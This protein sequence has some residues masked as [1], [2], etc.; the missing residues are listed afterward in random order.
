MIHAKNHL[1]KTL[2]QSDQGDTAKLHDELAH[3]KLRIK[4]SITDMKVQN[5]NRLRTK[6]LRADPSR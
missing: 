3:L 1:A 6:V 4:E 2:Q 5:R